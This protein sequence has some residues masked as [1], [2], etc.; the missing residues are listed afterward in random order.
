MTVTMT[1]TTEAPKKTWKE[2]RTV[3]LIQTS[4]SD[5]ET[6]NL[7]HRKWW[8]KKVRKLPMPEAAGGPFGTVAHNVFQRYLEADALGRDPNGQPVD[9]FPEGW[10]NAINRFTGL[11]EG[12]VTPAEASIIQQLVKEAIESG[13]LERVPDRAIEAR[14]T[15]DLVQLPCPTCKGA[16]SIPCVTCAGRGTINTIVGTVVET[17]R[18][19]GCTNGLATC[20]T[21]DGDGKGDHVTI[22]GFIDY[23][24][25]DSVQDHKT[26][27]RMKYAKSKNELEKDTQMLVYAKQLLDSIKRDGQPEPAK[28]SLRHNF[29]CKDPEDLRVRKTEVWV[30]PED[31]H[32]HWETL[33]AVAQEMSNVRRTANSWHQVAPPSN[34][35]RACQAYGGCP[36]RGICGGVESEEEYE[37]RYNGIKNNISNFGNKV[38]AQGSVLGYS[39]AASS[40]PL[41]EVSMATQSLAERFA[42]RGVAASGSPAPQTS[43]PTPAPTTTSPVVASPTAAPA[44]SAAASVAVAGAVPWAD[45]ACKSCG[46][47]GYNTQGNPCRICDFVAGKNSR[48]PSHEYD[49]QSDGAGQC[50][51][52]LKSDPSVSGVS[53]MVMAAAVKA[54]VRVQAP[55]AAQAPAPTPPT[56]ATA[57]PLTAPVTAAA[58]ATPPEEAKGTRN[59][60]RKGFILVINGVVTN[61]SGTAPRITRL[62]DTFKAIREELGT[63]MGKPYYELDAFKR[64][65]LSAD[66]AEAIANS[67]GTDYVIADLA[68]GTPDLKALCE[69]L[70]PFAAL[71]IVGT[72][73]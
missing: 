17:V 35:A 31:V 55:V 68:N 41:Q 5:L 58:V 50:M 44:P 7:C 19:D 14:F 6:F 22:T 11:S 62:V 59:T 4:A 25:P 9:L 15:D 18:C 23:L 72:A 40:S 30:T 37:A 70:R 28:I 67:F 8:A 57:A 2:A 60:K 54:E 27:K 51:W 46:G 38:L 24:T 33:K 10:T 43:S 47:L 12:T 69:V 64:R 1:T 73:I 49:V 36:F 26:G 20:P 42:A 71:E 52:V 21:C 53:P 32:S 63:K 3:R 48:K 66:A 56:S 34:M 45:P 61:G 16:G 29:Y 39:S 13:V 65:D